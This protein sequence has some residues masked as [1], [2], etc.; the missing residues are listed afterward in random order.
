M[1]R[2]QQKVAWLAD[3]PDKTADDFERED[4]YR[5]VAW[6]VLQDLI[7]EGC[8]ERV[9]PGQYR[10]TDKKPRPTDADGPNCL[11]AE[12]RHGILYVASKVVRP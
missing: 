2:D 11:L 5:F 4:P 10:W 6:C 7:L 1:T 12:A 9:G 8:L 3:H